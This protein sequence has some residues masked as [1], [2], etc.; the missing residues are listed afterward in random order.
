MRRRRKL[1]GSTLEGA[2][3]K[4]IDSKKARNLSENTIYWYQRHLDAFK[5]FS[6]TP[7]FYA[8]VRP[9]TIRSFLRYCI[10]SGLKDNTVHGRYRALRA[11]F[12]WM[13]R[14][15]LIT[16]NPMS[17]V[18]E[19]RT[20]DVII[21]TFTDV[22]L[23]RFF[24]VIDRTTFAGLRD[25]TLFS[26]LLDTGIRISE[27]LGIKQ[28][29]VFL[30]AGHLYVTGKGRKERMVPFGVKTFALLQQYMA[31][32]EGMDMLFINEYNGPL[33]RKNVDDRIKKYGKL[34]GIT[35]VRLSAHTFRHT[36]AISYL[37]NEGD[38]RHLKEILGHTSHKMVEVYTRLAETDIKQAHRKASP[39]DKL[40]L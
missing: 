18:D 2:I 3:K 26:L 12:N 28:K 25:Y 40:K 37:R 1:E 21:N 10:E 16:S 27:A 20:A 14:E 8:Y 5:S 30:S 32:V 22:E 33:S 35:D 19:P 11:F 13:E 31:L 34:A 23:K 4:F 24:A 39:V 17:K 9:D 38:S 6:E 29:N 15:E 7:S 36:F